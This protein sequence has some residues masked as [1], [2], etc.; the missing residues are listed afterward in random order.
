[1]LQL[2]ICIVITVSDQI[3]K[4]LI[5]TRI[6]P[7]EDVPVIDSFFSI[8]FGKNTGAAWGIMQGFNNWLVL[9]SILVVISLV[10]FRRHFFEDTRIHRVTMGLM[11][12][13]ILGNLID[14][15]K[16]GYVIDFLDFYHGSYHF[17]AFNIADA[18]ICSGVTLYIISVYVAEHKKLKACKNDDKSVKAGG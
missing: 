10:V 12:G 6:L 13:G 2:V 4:F 15:V 1:M 11:A 18:A 17:P 16:H 14:R 7:H 9:L 8:T 3:S 5:L